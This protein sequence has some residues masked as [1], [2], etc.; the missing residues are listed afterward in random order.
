MQPGAKLDFE[1]TS[2]QGATLITDHSTYRE[3]IERRGNAETYIKKHY[4]SWVNFAREEGHGDVKPILVI[5]VDLT[6]QFASMTYSDCNTRLGCDFSVGT[7]PGGSGSLGVWGSWSTEDP[8]VHTNCGPSPL[9]ARENQ[10]PSDSSSDPTPEF[11]TPADH[12]QCVFIRYYTMRWKIWVLRAGAGPHQLPDG[13]AG[14]YDDGT[15]TVAVETPD[16]EDGSTQ[17]AGLCVTHNAPPVSQNDTIVCSCSQSLSRMTA[18]AST[19]LQNSY[20]RSGFRQKHHHFRVTPPQRTDATSLLLHD[21]D[22][23]ELIDVRFLLF[24]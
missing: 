3:D 15:G 21:G 18:T 7:A 4:R 1:L 22:I 2:K 5:G 19:L 6:K 14:D 13:D 20:F 23:P 16:P 24:L 11:V 8:L 17:D 10:G 12:N 9:L